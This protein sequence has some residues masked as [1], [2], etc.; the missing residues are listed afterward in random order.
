MDRLPRAADRQLR[1]AVALG[2]APAGMHCIA[3]TR[4]ALICANLPCTP[5]SHA[6]EVE[7]AF[8]ACRGARTLRVNHSRYCRAAAQRTPAVAAV[9]AAAADNAAAACSHCPH[10]TS[11]PHALLCSIEFQLY[12]DPNSSNLGTTVWDAS[13]V[14]AKY[15]EKVSRQPGCGGLL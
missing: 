2:E 10:H 9:A 5:R 6:G 15:L 7:H 12:Q 14:L 4:V 8:L 1:A 3:L 13:I 11:P